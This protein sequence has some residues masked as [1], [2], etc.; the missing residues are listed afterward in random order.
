MKHLATALIVCS[1][2]GSITFLCVHFN[3]LEPIASIAGVMALF[4]FMVAIS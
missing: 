2:I 3:T 4:L 1:I